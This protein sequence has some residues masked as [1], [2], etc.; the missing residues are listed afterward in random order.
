MFDFLKRFTA[1]EHV[2]AFEKHPGVTI[3]GAWLRDALVNVLTGEKVPQRTYTIG[4]NGRGSLVL[5]EQEFRDLLMAMIKMAEVM[6]PGFV[7]PAPVKL[8]VFKPAARAAGHVLG[9]GGGLT[10]W[11]PSHRNSRAR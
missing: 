8:P 4:H 2:G 11:F 10:P 3:D 1:A 9:R 5:A 6:S 7:Q